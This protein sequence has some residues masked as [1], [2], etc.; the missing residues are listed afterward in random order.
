MLQTVNIT[1][2]LHEVRLKTA[3]LFQKLFSEMPY[4]YVTQKKGR[5]GRRSQQK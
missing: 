4:P 1:G 3:E 2:G 5:T